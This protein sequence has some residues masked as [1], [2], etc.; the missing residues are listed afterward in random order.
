MLIFLNRNK[1]NRD[2]R[3]V[4]NAETFN[5]LGESR[6]KSYHRV[7]SYNVKIIDN[8]K[9]SIFKILFDFSQPI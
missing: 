2:G 4:A 7:K 5:L 9:I 6:E 3:V 8:M 1:K